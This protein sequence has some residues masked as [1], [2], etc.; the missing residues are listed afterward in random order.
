MLRRLNQATVRRSPSTRSLSRCGTPWAMAW[1][2]DQLDRRERVRRTH[3]G[4]DAHERASWNYLSPF[5]AVG[6]VDAARDRG[7]RGLAKKGEQIRVK[8]WDKV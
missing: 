1:E 5:G 3:S 6:V 2:V 7:A 8:T 4:R